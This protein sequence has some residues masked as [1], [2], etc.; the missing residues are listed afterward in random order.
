M[1][2]DNGCFSSQE[3]CDLA[4][5]V[6]IQ[7]VRRIIDRLQLGTRVGRQ[8]VVFSE[9]LATLT[10]AFRTLGYSDVPDLT[11]SVPEEESVL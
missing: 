10:I 3:I 6:P 11:V 8:R 4:K 7:T 1:P 9:D 5:V 2:R